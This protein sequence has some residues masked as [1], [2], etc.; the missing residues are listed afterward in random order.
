M[1]LVPGSAITTVQASGALS[2]AEWISAPQLGKGRLD[3]YQAVR[4]WRQN[5]GLE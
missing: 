4:A 5:L 3:V 2:H 1:N